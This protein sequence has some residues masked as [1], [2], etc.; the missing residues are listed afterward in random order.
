[1]GLEIART[2]AGFSICQQ[3]FTLEI[4]EDSGLLAAKPVLFPMESNLKLCKDEGVLL[5]DA[6]KYRRLIGR[7]IYLTITR[8]DI[9]ERYNMEDGAYL[10]ILVY[11]ERKKP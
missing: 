10:H 9:K 6:T 1:L 8:L 2:A 7:L 5:D 3:K 4:L 11:L